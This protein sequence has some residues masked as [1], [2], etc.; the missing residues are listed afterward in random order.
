[1]K[2]LL[3]LMLFVTQWLHMKM[4]GKVLVSKNEIILEAPENRHWE[5]PENYNLISMC[6]M[7]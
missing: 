7:K 2:L 6:G 3:N 5:V 1:M 4:G